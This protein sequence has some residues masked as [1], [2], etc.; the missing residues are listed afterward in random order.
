MRFR[1]IW[2]PRRAPSLGL[3]TVRRQGPS[4]SSVWASAM[5]SGWRDRGSKRWWCTDLAG[6]SAVEASRVPCSSEPEFHGRR[7]VPVVG[8]V[9][10]MWEWIEGGRLDAVVIAL[11]RNLKNGKRFSTTRP[12]ELVSGV[13]D[14]PMSVQVV[15]GRQC[16]TGSSYFGAC[17]EI[18]DNN[19]VSSNVC[20][21]HG[22]RMGSHCAFG[23]LWRPPVM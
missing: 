19:F 1:S 4:P 17:T 7:R 3:V 20:L 16:D 12:K 14:M 2:V 15:M 10:V 11:N 23:Q 22:N 8:D 9:E 13:V 21:E 6:R 18:G 5:S